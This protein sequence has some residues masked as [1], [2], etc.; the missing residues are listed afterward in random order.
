MLY[1]V[2]SYR[3]TFNVKHFFNT[4][5]SKLTS[6]RLLII[7]IHSNCTFV[8]RTTASIRLSLIGQPPPEQLTAL[9][10]PLFA[11][12]SA[13][14]QSSGDVTEHLVHLRR[15]VPAAGDDAAYFLHH[16]RVV[17]RL[18]GFLV[19]VELVADVAHRRYEHLVDSVGK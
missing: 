7:V 4:S 3:N 10:P 8:T 16:L 15:F 19:A 13:R 5:N 17:V 12:S 14:G 1:E 18:V 2:N 9:R 11:F 6:N